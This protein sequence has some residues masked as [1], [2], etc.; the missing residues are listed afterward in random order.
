MA[1][2]DRI[3]S[4]LM[5]LVT[6]IVQTYN[7]RHSPALTGIL[8]HRDVQFLRIDEY[9]K[10]ASDPWKTVSGLAQF[11]KLKVVEIEVYR[12]TLKLSAGS[13]FEE[14]TD[15]YLV[16]KISDALLENERG[17]MLD[18]QAFTIIAYVNFAW[19]SRINGPLYHNVSSLDTDVF[20][21]YGCL[22][23]RRNASSI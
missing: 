9:Q 13:T 17:P 19:Y 3:V 14:L 5:P 10:L 12:C 11:K 7:R 1:A 23:F 8:Q 21:R 4:S 6:W 20:D 2:T 18:A 15:A 16:D 22:C